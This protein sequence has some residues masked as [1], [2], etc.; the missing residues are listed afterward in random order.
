MF[1]VRQVAHRIWVESAYLSKSERE[2]EAPPSED[3]IRRLAGELG[4]DSDIL[5]A[6]AGK[7]SSVLHNHPA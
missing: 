7:V 3:T 1:S 6:M 5:L 2:Q 4:E